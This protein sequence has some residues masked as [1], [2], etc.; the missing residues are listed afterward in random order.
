MRLARVQSLGDAADRIVTEKIIATAHHTTA[1]CRHVGMQFRFLSRLQYHA[2]KTSC[3]PDWRIRFLARVFRPEVGEPKCF[4][5]PLIVA[6]CLAPDN[7]KLITLPAHFI[8]H[9]SPAI[10]IFIHWKITVRV[11]HSFDSHHDYL[12]LCFYT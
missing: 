8:F 6:G 10:F 5:G 7:G 2:A 4:H 11:I 9:F 3:V 1:H 12:N